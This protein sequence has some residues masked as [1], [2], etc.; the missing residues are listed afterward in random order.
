MA[1]TNRVISIER[2]KTSTADSLSRLNQTYHA[3]AD[4]KQFPEHDYFTHD[5]GACQ[6]T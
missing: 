4:I 2:N 3:T 5:G 6:M 1:D